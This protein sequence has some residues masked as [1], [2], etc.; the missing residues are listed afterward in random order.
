MDS[1]INLQL[2]TDDPGEAQ[3][4]IE[5][6]LSALRRIKEQME[7]DREEI[8]RLKLENRAMFDQLRKAA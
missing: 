3:K 2:T 5:M 7:K 8:D 1:I 6:F 4:M